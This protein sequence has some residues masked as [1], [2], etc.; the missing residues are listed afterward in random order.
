MRPCASTFCGRA[1]VQK[2]TSEKS[3]IGNLLIK[4]LIGNLD[5]PPPTT[6][7]EVYVSKDTFKFNAAHFVAF[8][9]YRERLHGH[10]YRIGVR[11]L[12]RRQIGADGY[13]I[14]FGCVKDVCKK[15]CKRINEHFLCPVH[16]DVLKITTE[17]ES[18]R[19][20]CAD[21]TYF[22]F[23]AADC[24]MLPIFH[25]TAEEL[26]IYLYAEIL[27]G[28]NADYLQ[29]RGIHTMEIAVA[30]AIGQEATFRLEIPENVPDNFKLD[31]K[32]FITEGDVVPMPCPAETLSA[33]RNC[34]LD[35]QASKN[36]LSAQLQKLANAINEGKLREMG[37]VTG[38]DLQRIFSK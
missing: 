3:Y 4:L 9:G 31:V 36:E 37:D 33:K 11:L 17:N 10:N 26:A 15:V 38:D 6:S 2:R 23:P 22:V 12:G 24:V 20:E 30:E 25:A 7:F 16:S 1:L 29:K 35:C 13:L 19:I 5:M 27:N 8:Q 18:V 14:D 32:A 34:C 21:G 28:L